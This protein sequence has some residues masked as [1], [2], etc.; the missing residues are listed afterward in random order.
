VKCSSPSTKDRESRQLRKPTS[1]IATTSAPATIDK[2][3]TRLGWSHIAAKGRRPR[4]IPGFHGSA[5]EVLERPIARPTY[6][7]L[8]IST[9]ARRG[10][11]RRGQSRLRFLLRTLPPQAAPAAASV[12]LDER[13]GGIKGAPFNGGALPLPYLAKSN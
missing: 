10:V 9:L 11:A 6:V 2:S 3:Q 8:L 12:D 5:T 13:V 4:L 7:S 1:A